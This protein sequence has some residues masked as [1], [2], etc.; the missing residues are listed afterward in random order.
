MEVPVGDL[1]AAACLFA[2]EACVTLTCCHLVLHQVI[3]AGSAFLRSPAASKQPEAARD[4]ALSVAVAHRNLAAAYRA[5]PDKALHEA[6]DHASKGLRVLREF[7]TGTMLLAQLKEL[8][9]VRVG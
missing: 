5:H 1:G 8:M 4:I 2:D 3:D 7:G 9:L 6:Y